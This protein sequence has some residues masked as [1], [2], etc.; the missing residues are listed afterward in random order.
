MKIEATIT[1]DKKHV[2]LDTGEVYSI[3]KYHR[4]YELSE[5]LRVSVTID[6]EYPESCDTNPFC[7]GD[8]TCIECLYRN[9]VANLIIK[10]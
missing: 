8:E 2:K 6:N 1:E 10:K 9:E 7:E 3:S 5:G 4:N